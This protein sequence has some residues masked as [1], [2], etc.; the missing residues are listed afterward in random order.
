MD[1]SSVESPSHSIDVCFD[2]ALIHVSLAL[3]TRKTEH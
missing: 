1:E 2:F 3:N